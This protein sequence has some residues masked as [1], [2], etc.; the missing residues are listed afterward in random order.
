MADSDTTEMVNSAEGED[1]EE[2]EAAKHANKPENKKKSHSERIIN[3]SGDI[4]LTQ[5]AIT[6]I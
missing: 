5:S 4:S 3:S 2:S 1:N 6:F